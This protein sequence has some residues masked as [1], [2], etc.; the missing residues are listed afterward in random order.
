MAA[1]IEGGDRHRRRIEQTRETHF[2]GAQIFGR[3]LTGCAIENE[4]AR[5]AGH[6]ILTECDAMQEPH[7]Q[8]L[9]VAAFQIDVDQ[10]GADVTGAAG[11][12]RKQ[13]RAVAGDEIGNG[14]AAR[15]DLREVVIQPAGKGRVHVGDAA[16]RIGREEAGRR[17]IE[18]IDRVLQF[19]EHVLVPLAL[20]RDVG[21]APQ[22]RAPGAGP[23][24]RTHAHAIPGNRSIAEERRREA[25]FLRAPFALPRGESQPID[26]FGN[27]RG[28]GKQPV[29]KPQFRGVARTRKGHIGVVRIDRLALAVRDQQ[30]LGVRVG[31]QLGEVVARPLPCKLNES[32]SKREKR[33]D[34]DHGK[35]R[36]QRQNEPLRLIARQHGKG[37]NRG[38]Q[39]HGQEQHQAGA[40]GTFRTIDSRGGHVAHSFT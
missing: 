16:L 6:R 36:Q 27:V 14:E 31:K 4:R 35:Q 8:A 5:N 25:Q 39:E 10:F 15:P 33:E 21:H 12:R 37:D 30:A 20:A 3:L 13:R 32:D 28:T 40:A 22:R 1:A 38:N 29:D 23:L 26:R 18:E 24:E 19:L 17:M 2:R 34:A 11:N 9:A 7:R